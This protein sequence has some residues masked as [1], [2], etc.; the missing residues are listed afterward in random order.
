MLNIRTQDRMTLVPY[1]KPIT[2]TFTAVLNK[3]VIMKCGKEWLAMYATKERALEVLDEI[4]V[5]NDKTTKTY[6]ITYEMP[7]DKM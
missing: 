3:E 7:N 6:N 4:Q 5:A 2:I 1:N